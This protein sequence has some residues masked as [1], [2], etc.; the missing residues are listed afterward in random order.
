V[1]G[2]LAGLILHPE[3]VA[4]AEMRK[5]GAGAR[6]HHS[7]EA[8]TASA[9]PTSSASSACWHTWDHG[10]AAAVF[11]TGMAALHAAFFTLLNPG[12]HAIVS[13]VVYIRVWGSST[14]CCDQ[15]RY[16]GLIRGHHRPRCVG[17]AVRPNTRLIHTEV[18]A[19]PEGRRP[20]STAYG[21]AAA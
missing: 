2:D 7:S 9:G 1:A 21:P 11:G 15:A 13:N 10:E 16:R 5:V 4:W 18:V 12:D 8:H 20:I 19:N 17:A 14:P 3:S 6:G